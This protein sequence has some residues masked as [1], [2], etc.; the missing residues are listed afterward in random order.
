VPKKKIRI[1][2]GDRLLM[3]LPEAA[4]W[5]DGKV[6]VSINGTRFT[7]TEDNPQIREVL[8][9]ATEKARRGQGRINGSAFDEGPAMSCPRCKG[10]MLVCEWH[11]DKPWTP[12]G[13]ECGAGMPCLVCRPQRSALG[14]D[15]AVAEAVRRAVDVTINQVFGRR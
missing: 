6:T 14:S 12:E 9:K 10:A 5:P 15:E 8:K 11:P 2:P 7:F 3:E 13:C 4:T 1:E